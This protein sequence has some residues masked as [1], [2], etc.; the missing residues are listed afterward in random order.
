MVTVPST[1]AVVAT[2]PWFAERLYAPTLA[3]QDATHLVMTFAGY[4]VQT[5]GDDLLDY[6]QIG[7]VSLTVSRALVSAPNNANTH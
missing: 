1:P 6:R 5:P 2:E 4:G 7:H 3:Q